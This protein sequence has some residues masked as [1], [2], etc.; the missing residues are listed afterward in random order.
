[1]TNRKN[2]GDAMRDVNRR[3]V[4]ASA[5]LAT[6][7][8]APGQSLAAPTGKDVV[9]GFVGGAVYFRK[10]NPPPEE[11]TRDYR[12]ASAVGMTAF[13]HW[14]MWSAIEIA[15][16]KYDWSDYDRQMDLAAQNGIKTIIAIIDNCAPEWAFHK[17][18]ASR[19]L[20][21]DGTRADS[22]H[23]GSSATPSPSF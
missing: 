7:A 12:A 9:T 15:P 1:M 4:I 17:F 8:L 3:S 11:W 6:P 23:S 16:G 5:A 21:S 19:Y 10:S 20:A 22:L 14:F 18:P 13:R 2:L